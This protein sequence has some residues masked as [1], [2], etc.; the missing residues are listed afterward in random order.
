M[1]GRNNIVQDVGRRVQQGSHSLRSLDRIKG[2]QSRRL[3]PKVFKMG[4]TRE[5]RG[6]V[7]LSK[8][9]KRVKS[10]PYSDVQEFISRNS[11][12]SSSTVNYLKEKRG[13]NIKDI[14]WL[15]DKEKVVDEYKKK[16]KHALKALN[17]A[18]K[19]HFGQSRSLFEKGQKEFLVKER[20]AVEENH[21]REKLLLNRYYA[22]LCPEDC[23]QNGT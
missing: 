1:I 10:N 15:F 11:S 21:R 7:C 8:R 13:P 12:S 9:Y 22:G 5:E 14:G 6:V 2:I 3:E 23:S 17:E 20:E 18:G 16:K 4:R 19:S